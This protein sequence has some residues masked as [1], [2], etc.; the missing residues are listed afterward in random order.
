[1]QGP[2]PYYGPTRAMDSLNEFRV[3]GTFA[4]IGEDGDHFLKFEKW[5]MTQL[6][7][8]RFNVNNHA[9]IIEGTSLCLARWFSCFFRHR[10]LTPH[11]TRQ[12]ANRY[13]LRK[14][15]VLE[16]RMALP[17][18]EEQSSIA[19]ALD[20]LDAAVDANSRRPQGD[21]GAEGRAHVGSPHRRN[22]RQRRPRSRRVTPP[23]PGWNEENLSENPAVEHLSGLGYT[24]VAPE[25]LDAE[26]ESLKEVVLIQAPRR[27]AQEAQ[28][29]ALRRQR[30]QGRPR[31]H[32]RPGHQPH[33]GEREA[34]HHAHLRHLARA[35]SA[36]TARRATT[37]RFFDFDDADEQRVR[38]HPPV[39]GPGR[40]EEHPP[41]RHALRERHPARHHRVQEPDA[42]RGVE[43]RGH[44]PVLPLPGAGGASTASWARR[45]SSRPSRSSSPPAARPPCYGTVATPHRFFAEWKTPYPRTR[46]RAR[47][48]DLGRKPDRRRRSS[49]RGCSRPR[50]SSTSSATSSSSSATRRPGGRSASSAATSSSPP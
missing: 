13:K 24:Y 14:A 18:P 19:D 7:S 21:P 8:G 3:D 39:Q 25:A 46:G 34:L 5:P 36:A 30:P 37:V 38:R 32:R 45:S 50:T 44:R 47:K 28:P 43:G 48:R 4:L 12:G 33:R 41:R 20:R 15:T 27:R 40:E 11:L 2:Y 1:M 23:T 26:R 35:G 16:L 9:H 10:D 42:R 17:S 49:S 6:V 31:R 22:P 29:L